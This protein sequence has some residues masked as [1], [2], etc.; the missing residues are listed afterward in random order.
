MVMSISCWHFDAQ[1]TLLN[2]WTFLYI[3]FDIIL[4]KLCKRKIVLI[5]LKFFKS[6]FCKL[7]NKLLPYKTKVL[8]KLLKLYSRIN[9][10]EEWEGRGGRFLT[11]SVY[12]KLIWC[13]A[14]FLHNFFFGPLNSLAALINDFHDL[15]E[16]SKH[17][18]KG[19]I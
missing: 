5:F 2:W 18:N 16:V 4:F 19:S 1:F 3:Y 14:H 10:V 12:L 9:Q 17:E 6:I 8:F 15:F 13:K 11:K 7:L